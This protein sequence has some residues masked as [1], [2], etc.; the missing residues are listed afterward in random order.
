LLWRQA[1]DISVDD[2]IYIHVHRQCLDDSGGSLVL[3]SS[4]GVQAPPLHLPSTPHLVSFLS[5]LDAALAP[6]HRLNPPLWLNKDRGEAT[7]D[8][9]YQFQS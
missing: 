7:F 8:L 2:I 5:T 6:F 3:V 1:L 9:E 4:D